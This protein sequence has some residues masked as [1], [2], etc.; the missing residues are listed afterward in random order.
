MQN[1]NTSFPAQVAS[2]TDTDGTIHPQWFRFKNS[3]GEL[4]TIKNFRIKRESPDSN[5]IGKNFLCVSA[6]YGQEQEFF[7]CYN[8]S[9]HTWTIEYRTTEQERQYLLTGQT[10]LQHWA[11]VPMKSL[12]PSI[13]KIK[14]S[15]DSEFSFI[16][17]FSL[18]S[19]FSSS[20]SETA[21]SDDC[22]VLCHT[23]VRRFFVKTD[24]I[25]SFL[26]LSKT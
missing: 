25:L 2:I 9:R 11:F 19:S 24:T 16:F 12:F 21:T 22:V 10:R 23:I 7:L 17:S 1:E 5:L 14:Q 4:I 3:D 6:V 15:V 20:L 13:F 18:S 26:D 8:Y